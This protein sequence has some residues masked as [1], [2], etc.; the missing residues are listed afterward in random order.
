MKAWQ[1][2]GNGESQGAVAFRK[3]HGLKPIIRKCDNGGLTDVIQIN[4][5]KENVAYQDSNF[6][7]WTGQTSTELIKAVVN[8]VDMV[9]K[10]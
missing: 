3:T 8:K 1:N 4:G 9:L 7:Q 5:I 6:K 10:E 2:I